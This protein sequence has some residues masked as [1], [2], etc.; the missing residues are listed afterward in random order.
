MQS[1]HTLFLFL[2][3]VACG[4]ATQSSSGGGD[5][6]TADAHGDTSPSGDDASS[7]DGAPSDSPGTSDSPAYDACMSDAGLLDYSL[8]ACQSDGD[9]HI[10]QE[11]TDCCGT[12]LYVGV[13]TASVSA[14]TACENAW[15][16]HFPACGCDSGQTKTEDGKT[17]NPGAG[18]DAGAPQVHCTD[19][20][21]N[22]GV[23]L[24]Y[25]P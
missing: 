25:T 9:C 4:G 21:S 16:M 23:C 1:R 20:T 3:V 14:F 11:Q 10:E 15:V 18:G 17:T 13:S 22:G 24:T 8:K 12:I 5:A 6:S 2:A 19:F 7:S